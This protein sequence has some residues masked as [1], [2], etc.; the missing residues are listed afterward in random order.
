MAP[1][2][3]EGVK[4][5]DTASEEGKQKRRPSRDIGRDLEFKNERDGAE[6]DDVASDNDRLTISQQPCEL[7][8]RSSFSFHCPFLYRR[9]QN[10]LPSADFSLLVAHSTLLR[11]PAAQS[12]ILI[13]D[14]YRQEREA[15]VRTTLMEI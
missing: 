15:H 5:T 3:R 4:L 11:R 6:D 10:F 9:R 8:S 12:S 2:E 1:K 7:A 13:C 14:L